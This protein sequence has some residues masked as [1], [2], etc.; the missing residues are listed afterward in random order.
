MAAAGSGLTY[1]GADMAAPMNDGTPQ[2]VFERPAEQLKLGNL[3][4]T[5]FV[6]TLKLDTLSDFLHLSSSEAEVA[7][8]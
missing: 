3:I 2:E 1:T 8:S 5:C 4:T 7:R 6:D